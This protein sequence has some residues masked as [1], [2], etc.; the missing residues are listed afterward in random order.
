MS[1]IRGHWLFTPYN[2]RLRC[3]EV[4]FL[5]TSN[6]RVILKKELEKNLFVFSCTDVDSLHCSLFSL[7][8]P[9]GASGTRIVNHLVYALEPGQVGVASIC[10][11]GGGASSIMIE[12]L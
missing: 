5:K 11:G 8:H 12:R 10:N 1:R 2:L 7:G 4:R 9:L 3:F 6:P